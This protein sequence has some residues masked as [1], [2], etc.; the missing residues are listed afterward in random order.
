MI[1]SLKRVD[2]EHKQDA[3]DFKV[4]VHFSTGTHHRF[5]ISKSISFFLVE[6][7]HIPQKMEKG[8]NSRNATYYDSL[9]PESTPE[10]QVQRELR[11]KSSQHV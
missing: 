10:K 11:Q 3:T 4:R 2:F 7:A 5:N 6:R 1:M 9:L 8:K